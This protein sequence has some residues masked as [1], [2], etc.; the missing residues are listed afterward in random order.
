MGV[1]Y[2]AR[3]RTL[4]RDV[5]LKVMTD[6]MND[7]PVFR[8]RFTNEASAAASVD[9]RNVVPVFHASDANGRLYVVMKFVQGTD[10]REVLQREH[11]LSAERTAAIVTDVAEAL[12]A[13]H[14]AGLVHRDVKPANIL[15]T[16]DGDDERAM[17]TDFGL[18]KPT[19][20]AQ[21]L[22]SMHTTLGTAT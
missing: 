14:A 3:D 16:R 1:V 17:L 8:T 22:T 13:V 9:N 10:L 4:S 6:D 5:A 7:D 20:G 19:I 12:R 11:Q 2:L 18:A 21:H 15:L